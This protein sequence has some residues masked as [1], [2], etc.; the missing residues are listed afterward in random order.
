MQNV[1]L[2][3]PGIYFAKPSPGT[4]YPKIKLETLFQCL[5]DKFLVTN[6]FTNKEY[7]D[8]LIDNPK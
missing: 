5:M 8:N 1:H 7:P 6:V 3:M 2:Q 4:D